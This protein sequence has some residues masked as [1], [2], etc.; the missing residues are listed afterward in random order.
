MCIH[1]KFHYLFLPEAKT[2]LFM[3]KLVSV[4]KPSVTIAVCAYN[5]EKNIAK[6]LRLVHRQIQRTYILESII[7]ISDGSIDRTVTRAL[8]LNHAKTKIIV[9]KTRIGKSARLNELYSLIKSDI[10]VQSDCDVFFAKKDVIDLLIAPLLRSKKVGMSGGNPLPVRA[11]TFV[12]SSVNRTCMVYSDF[13]RQVRGG[14]NVF[15]A[16]G[17]L[18]AF[19]KKLYKQVHVPE[20]MIANDMYMYFFALSKG[21]AYRFVK[22]AVVVFRS[23]Q[24]VSDHVRQNTRFLAAPIRM[25]R[26]FPAVLVETE[27]SIPHFLYFVTLIKHFLLSPHECSFIYSLNLYCKLL[28]YLGEKKMSALWQIARSTKSI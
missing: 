8:E 12:E 9:H 5:E 18:L 11:K 4:K 1:P 23:P 7:V 17:R 20:S 2:K 6:F 14:N 27:I 10:L 15:S 13:R 28:S 26:Y 19:R 25:R 22:E 24:T 16:D 3:K 21:F